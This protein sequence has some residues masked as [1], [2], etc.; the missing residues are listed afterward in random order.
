MTYRFRC[1]RQAWARLKPDDCGRM[2]EMIVPQETQH[3]LP[4][5]SPTHQIA[6]ANI[7][8]RTWTSSP[9]HCK[10]MVTPGSIRFTKLERFKRRRVGRMCGESS[11][12]FRLHI[13]LRSPWKRWN[14]SERCMRSK[15]R[16]ADARRKNAVRLETSAAGRCWNH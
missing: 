1:W 3:H 6:R 14:G 2:Y 13:N 8:K 4:C 12:I 7:R 5:G 9:G 11:T 15:K 10:R 16:S